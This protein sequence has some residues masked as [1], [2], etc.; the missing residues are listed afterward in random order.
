MSFTHLHLH[1]E[2]SLLDGMIRI[3]ELACRLKELNMTSCAITDHGVMYGIIDFYKT[4]LKN[5]IKPIIG[6]EAYITPKSI[7]EREKDE[8]RFHIVLLARDEAGYKNLLKM[9]SRSF[10]EGFYYKPRI[11][12]QI[13]KEH[14][15]GIVALSACLQGEIAKRIL[16]EGK[17]AARKS[18]KR[19]LDILGK[20][21]FFIEVQNHG[22][23]EEI[24]VTKVALELAK[25][26]G[27]KVVAT[28]DAHYLKK[29]DAKAHDILLCVQ[30]QARADDTERMRYPGDSFYLKSEQEMR[31]LF[32]EI[33]EVIENTQL[34]AE[35]CNVDLKFGEYHLPRFVENGQQW[36]PEHNKR[37]LE[38]LAIEGVKKLYGETNE[39][40]IKQARYEIEVIEK[41]G[42]TD[43][44]LI[45]HD[46]IKWAKENDI[47]VGP[48]RG[49]AAGSIVSYALGITGVDP[50]KYQLFFERFLNP[51]RISMPDIDIDFG[52]RERDRVIEYVRKKYGEDHVAQVAT[53]GRMEA[54]MVLR[55]VGRVLNFTYGEVGRIAKLVPVNTS[56]KEALSLV[57]DLKKYAQDPKYAQL[58]EIALRLEGIIRNFSTHAAGIV[59]GD[60]PLTEYVPLQVDK[61]NSVITQLDK[62]MIEY[63]GLLKM[64]FLGLKNL[65]IIKD[66]VKM[67]REKAINLDLESLPDGDKKTFEMLKQG[68]SAGVF[69][70]ESS[71]MRR[72]LKGVQPESIEDL[73]AVISLY[74]PGTIKAGGIEEYIE[75]K[76][77]TKKVTYP[78][79]EVEAV[80][81][82]TY[83]IIVYQ[84]QVMQIANVLAGYTMA[85]ADT[86]RK[87]IGKKIPEIMAAQRGK[88]V[89]RAT[90]RGIDRASA[91]RIFD[92]IEY[93]AGYGFNKSH[94]VSY[95]T[96]AYRT[97]YLKAH[98]PVEYF[99]AIL[100]SYIGNEDKTSQLIYEARSKGIDVLPPDINKSDIYFRTEGNAIRMGMLAIKNV[101]EKAL[102]EIVNERERNS[103]F[104]SFK[105]FSRRIEP[106]K[107]NKKVV[108]SLI[109]AGCFD[110]L[111]EDRKALME[112][113]TRNISENIFL[114]GGSE[115][116][117]RQSVTTSMDILNYEKE[118]FGF[119]LTYNPLSAYISLL[120][121]KNYPT[122][123]EVLEEII[124]H[125]IEDV[126]KVTVAGILTGARKTKTK[127][128]NFI[129]RF[130]I[131]DGV[132]KLESL[133][134]PRY[135]DSFTQ[136]MEKEGVI[137]AQGEIRKEEDSITFFAQSVQDFISPEEV[138]KTKKYQALHIYV[139]DFVENH[140]EVMEKLA[141]FREEATKIK[142]D[143]PVVL[144][145]FVEGK[146][147]KIKAS[148]KIS[149]SV[150]E[151]FV[152]KLEE[153]FGKGN[154]SIKGWGE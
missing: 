81:K 126:E 103:Y 82:N 141:K 134:M 83:G 5:G 107:V 55:D 30:T 79:P 22:I 77:G 46:F 87:A 151:K 41:M 96:I 18:V 4:L 152:A 19:Y 120:N 138:K 21:N 44:F 140:E 66:T 128:G 56:L 130:S 47:P 145:V 99:T 136:F 45:V 101:G 17:E 127:T 15:Q 91:E 42:F 29:E 2:Y 53:F 32:T 135:L 26:E 51:E 38:E 78:H 73:T 33:P 94:A 146:E 74:R 125:E 65:T 142:G 3:D 49:S 89:E 139:K 106:L 28:N 116:S 68:D 144:H 25:E 20:E 154:I 147:L 93:F 85:E 111:N 70:L 60:K 113:D 76:N 114:F 95:A 59:I 43:Y 57:A 109:K 131:E 92:L 97:A 118:I 50:L 148:P 54:K 84:E 121:E 48:G 58:F 7:K 90:Q 98:Y 10:I 23:E 71:G 31:D 124:Q 40:A 64:D 153:I 62:D 72:V 105:D 27:L 143:S 117:R 34:V 132:S 129:Y 1:T 35:M 12:F 37:L 16:N 150:S 6:I 24:T 67:L 75:R 14:R 69:Q 61:E 88:F 63:I 133:V 104:T 52:D 39:E 8:E 122:V 36:N 149:L 80:L 110:S 123:S 9:A 108:E 86:L 115:V 102:C 112:G 100:N 119:Y 137:V 11:D 13:L